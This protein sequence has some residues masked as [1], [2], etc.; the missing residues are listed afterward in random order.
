MSNEN[1]V[2]FEAKIINISKEAVVISY[3][4]SNLGQEHIYVFNMLYS[5]DLQG[6]RTLVPELAYS[7]LNTD[8]NY[9]VGK[10]L[11][12]IPSGIKVEYP[13]IPYLDPIQPNR[14]IS[15]QIKLKLPMSTLL[16]YHKF[17]DSGSVLP[18]KKIKVQIGFIK[19]ERYSEDEAVISPA[20]GVGEGH[21]ICDYGL[22]LRYQEYLEHT[23]IAKGLS[24]F[25][26][27]N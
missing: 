15:G 24:F 22:G 11:V 8:R 6:N 3:T 17:K 12:K 27:V 13:E 2:K 7:Y 16:P 10:F 5:T 4:I 19:S 26:G 20:H 25:T 1:L 18:I 9:I 23:L 14:F 21:Y